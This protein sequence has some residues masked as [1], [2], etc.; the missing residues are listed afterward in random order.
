MARN[1]K[2]RLGASLTVFLCLNTQAAKFD[3]SA[4]DRELKM[5]GNSTYPYEEWLNIEKGVEVKARVWR[6]PGTFPEMEEIPHLKD[7]EDIG[8]ASSGGG[9]RSAAQSFGV[10][11]VLHARGYMKTLRYMTGNSGGS[12]VTGPLAYLPDDYSIETWLGGPPL[13]PELLTLKT[14]ETAKAGS[15]LETFGRTTDPSQTQMI[16]NAKVMGQMPNWWNAGVSLLVFGPQGTKDGASVPAPPIGTKAYDRAKAAVAGTKA[17][18]YPMNKNAAFPILVSSQLQTLG[19]NITKVTA[20]AGFPAMVGGMMYPMEFT[21]LYSGSPMEV[22]QDGATIGGG[23]VENFGLGA[24]TPPVLPSGRTEVKNGEE[25][26]VTPDHFVPPG[27][28]MAASINTGPVYG[29]VYPYQA[30]TPEG[31]ITPAVNMWSPADTTSKAN[32]LT[33]MTDGFLIDNL[34]LLPLVARGVKRIFSHVSMSLGIENEAGV[35][36]GF[37]YW[38]AYFGRIDGPGAF[39]TPEGKDMQNTVPKV[40]KSEAFDELWA[41][42]QALDKAQKP[43]V[44][45]QTLDVLENKLCG[46]KGGYKVRILWMFDSDPL[47]EWKAKLPAETQKLMNTPQKGRRLAAVGTY[48]NPVD[49]STMYPYYGATYAA[50]ERRL[51]SL[52]AQNGAYNLE[53]AVGPEYGGNALD[54]FFANRPPGAPTT[55][56]AT[57]APTPAPVDPCAPATTPAPAPPTTIAPVDPC[58]PHTTSAPLDPCAPRLFDAD[59]KSKTTSAFGGMFTSGVLIAMGL[60]TVVIGIKVYKTISTRQD[61]RATFKPLSN[62]GASDLNDLELSAVE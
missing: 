26:S 21:P 2:Q 55:A 1:G 44:V 42:L 37:L 23:V 53:Q 17:K 9:C 7:K 47:P 43:L 39:G 20:P 24:S 40:F 54:N 33:I 35:S 10:A 36:K 51:L 45:D 31:I 49:I 46:V 14:L 3:E 19:L 34:A 11:K 25:V 61:S 41:K 50:W 27:L 6:L 30:V 62:P 60:L 29:Q 8:F 56:A 32:G 18:V 59:S 12:L 5:A 22:K 16:D 15:Y 4:P 52:L 13:R 28:G 57:P 38:P 48:D 58:A